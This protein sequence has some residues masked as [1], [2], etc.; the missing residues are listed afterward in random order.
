[1]LATLAT[2]ALISGVT[3]ARSGPVDPGSGDTARLLYEF[4]HDTYLENIAVRPNGQILV[5]PL[6]FPQLWLVDPDL[7]GEACVV[8]EFPDVLGLSGI[9]EYQPDIFAVLTGNFSFSTDNPGLGTWAIWSID[10]GGVY[11]TSNETMVASPSVVKKIAAIP[12]ATFLNGLSVLSSPEKDL[13]IAGDVKTG[14]IYKVDTETGEYAVVINNSYTAPVDTSGLGIVGTDGIK[15]VEDVLYF[16]NAGQG[17]LVKVSLNTSDGT[18]AGGFEV[19]ATRLTAKDQW[20]DFSIDCEGNVL[21]ATGGANTV[22]II[23]LKGQV[24]IVAGRLNSTAIAEGTSTAF[25]R[26]RDDAD[27]LYVA[28]AGGAAEPVNGDIIIGGQVLAVKTNV[29]GSGCYPY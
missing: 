18:P 27:V 1:M 13:L 2:L 6:S 25:G 28:T 15:V 20:D 8:H 19:V 26:R 11:V 10:L 14:V 7:P 12:E 24:D 22:E 9:V 17:I 5:N 4:P 29:R 16:D 3:Y 23:S 21:I